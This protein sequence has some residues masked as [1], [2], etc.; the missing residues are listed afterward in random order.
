M[1]ITNTVAKQQQ[2]KTTPIQRENQKPQRNERNEQAKLPSVPL[3][4]ESQVDSLHLALVA[5]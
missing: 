4:T 5:R 3:H 2:S 1:Q